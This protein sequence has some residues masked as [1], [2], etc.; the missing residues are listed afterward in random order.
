MIVINFGRLIT[1]LIV[2]GLLG[3]CQPR[4]KNDPIIRAVSL[5][6]TA[7][8][9]QY[10]AEGGDPNFE[11]RDGN[12]L[13]YVAAGPRGGAAVADLLLKAGANPD[14]FSE[15]GRTALQNAAS[16]CA[17]ETIVLLLN[18]GADLDL[19]SKDG[20]TALDVVCKSPANKRD[21]VI[22]AFQIVR[23]DRG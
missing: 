20:E 10:L 7:L 21:V 6:D 5:N 1:L 15:E 14:A 2:V 8:V 22:E 11:S 13:I 17:V 19:L 12:P 3:A 9:Q 18:A 23:A 16:W 4:Q